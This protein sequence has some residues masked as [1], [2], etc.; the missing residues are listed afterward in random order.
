MDAFDEDAQRRT[1]LVL[2]P[3]DHTVPAHAQAYGVQVRLDAMQL[4]RPRQ[5]GACWLACVLYE[6]LEPDRFWASRLP[7]S[8]EDTCW[9]YI[10]QDRA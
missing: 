4:H 8:R 6:Q 2:F 3:A 10:L 7:D 1:Q 5:W 9:Q